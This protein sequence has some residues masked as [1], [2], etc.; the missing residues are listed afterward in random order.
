MKKIFALLCFVLAASTASAVFSGHYFC[1]QFGGETHQNRLY[2]STSDV[3]AHYM[4]VRLGGVPL[5][6]MLDST[7]RADAGH[8]RAKVAGTVY[9]GIPIAHAYYT[10]WGSY[11]T[12]ND[13]YNFPSGIVV[14]GNGVYVC[15]FGNA[16]IKQTT[17]SGTFVRAWGSVGT[18]DGQFDIGPHSIAADGSGNI[19]VTNGDVNY[20]VQK[21]SSTG[22]F[23]T[24]WGSSGTGDGQ[25]KS[26]R[27]IAVDSSGYVYVADYGNYRVQKFTSTGTFVTKWGSEGTGN[28]QF[29]GIKGIAV[30]D[31]GYIWVVDTVNQNV[32]RFSN[33]GTY[34]SK[35]TSG[36][37]SP[38]GVACS[39]DGYIF[40]SDT[41]TSKINK[42]TKT[43]TLITSWGTNGTGDGQFDRLYGIGV[44]G[45]GNIFA[46]D[47]N[48][49]RVQVFK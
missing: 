11:G 32:Q 7:S 1:Y 37:S 13:N 41:G 8:F 26:M 34:Q 18:G 47:G 30:D 40:V 16:R 20:R 49:D 42:Y 9:A 31:E 27:G 39:S 36:L 12:G 6:M 3:G 15:D 28:G 29:K 25:F 5:Y 46:S 23:I 4:G 33:T 22:T 44:D 45:D 17:I 43:G 38:W 48:N 35:I 24:K 19:Y 2:T 14:N 21:F 10:K